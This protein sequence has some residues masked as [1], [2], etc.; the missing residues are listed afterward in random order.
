MTDSE[1]EKAVQILK[2][3]FAPIEFD[4][5][6]GNDAESFR[7]AY[8]T[9]HTPKRSPKFEKGGYH[10]KRLDCSCM[11]GENFE[12]W[13][14]HPAEVYAHSDLA[15]V[16]AKQKGKDYI[17][18]RVIVWPDKKTCQSIYTAD[19]EA[20][21]LVSEYLKD[22]G[23]SGDGIS[24]ARVSK[25]QHGAGSYLMP[26]VDGEDFIEDYGDHFVIGEGR[27]PIT[28]TSGRISIVPMMY[29]DDCGSY[30]PEEEVEFIN[31]DCYCQSCR[32]SNFV[33]SELMD[34]YISNEDYY[35]SGN[36]EVATS[37]YFEENGYVLDHE[38]TYQEESECVEYK[39][40]YYHESSYYVTK[41]DGKYYH[42]DSDEYQTALDL[43]AR[44]DAAYQTI[45]TT[46]F[47]WHKTNEF[48]SRGIL[49]AVPTMGLYTTK[50]KV[51]R[52]NYQLNSDGI[53]ERLPEFDF[54]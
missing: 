10:L 34:S 28:G 54:A 32:D 8:V 53:P 41:F 51:L 50:E 15:I 16:Y 33:W 45:E 46:Q 19:D 23:Y 17:G 13:E 1:V 43:K 49:V 11:R 26:Y 21:R 9:P 12:D 20:T 4:L 18:A 29:C 3:Q 2:E 37:E 39:G 27:I 22:N 14:K 38:G 24:G 36:G 5:H 35:V 7:Y 40:E 42:E 52:D 48:D 44:K 25:I 31:G 47:G 30:Y 6:V